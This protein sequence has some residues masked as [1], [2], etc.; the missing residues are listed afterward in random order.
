MDALRAVSRQSDRD[1]VLCL[2]TFLALGDSELDLLALSQ[3]LV[4]GA[5]DSAEVGKYVGAGFLLDKAKTL[6]VIEPFNGSSCRRHSH[7]PIRS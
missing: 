1:D 4:A 5:S 3:R 6:C 2:G 7:I